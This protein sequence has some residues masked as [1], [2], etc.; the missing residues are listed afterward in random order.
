MDEQLQQ[1]VTAL[2]EDFELTGEE[3]ADVLWLTVQREKYPETCQSQN[4]TN[5]KSLWS[6]KSNTR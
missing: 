6:R 5:T 1:L 4:E 3:I 2:G